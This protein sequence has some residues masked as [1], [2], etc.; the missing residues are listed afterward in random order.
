MKNEHHHDCST[1]RRDFLCKSASVGAAIPFITISSLIVAC[2][3]QEGQVVNPGVFITVDI[4]T[5]PELA[6]VPSI[7]LTSVT[8][9]NNGDP[10]FISRVTTTAFTVFTGICTHSG[11]PINPP[12]APLARLVCPY[13][14]AEFSKADG[15]V[16]KQPSSGSARNLPTFTATFDPSKNILSITP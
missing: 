8:G 10:V 14:N 11:N 16:Q 6:A 15:T 4:S 1:S 9:L 3:K 5:I 12:E 2:E 7:I 13:H